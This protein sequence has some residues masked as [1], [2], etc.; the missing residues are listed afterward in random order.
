MPA[1]FDSSTGAAPGET[2]TGA[3]ATVPGAEALADLDRIAVFVLDRERR[4]ERWSPAAAR[5]TGRPVER[6]V[7]AGVGTLFADGVG[8]QAAQLFRAAA[9]TG[10]S[11]GFLP[12]R[13]ADGRIFDVGFRA[14]ALRTPDGRDQV[15]VLAI[16]AGGLRRDGFAHAVFQTLFDQVPIGIAVYDEQRRFMRV[17]RA[18]AE[19]DG[20]SAP[21]H[22]GRRIEEVLSG[23]DD[24]VPLLQQHVL[25]TGEPVRDAFVKAG[26][27]K[28]GTTAAADAGDRRFW[29]MSHARLASADGQV[30]GLTGVIVDVTERQLAFERDEANRRRA[31]VLSAVGDRVAAA[32]DPQRAADEL[33]QA[34]VPAFCD[35]AAIYLLDSADDDRT[36]QAGMRITASRGETVSRH[37]DPSGEFGTALLETL[38]A[39]LA[40]GHARV[41]RESDNRGIVVPLVAHD[42][43]LGAVHFTRA[44]RRERF[45]AADLETV[46]ELAA[47]AAISMDNARLYARERDTA[48]LLQRSLLPERLPT[49]EGTRVAYRYRPGSVGAQV[50]G[51]WFDVIPLPSRRVAFVVGDVMGSG[52]RAAGIMGQFRTAARTL[53]QLDLTPAQVLRE[54]DELARSMS[55][56]H[57]ATCVYAIYNPVEGECVM[58][59]AGHPPPLLVGPGGGVDLVHLE[60]GAPLGVGGQR[61]EEYAFAVD[62]ASALALYT[63]GLVEARDRDI[64][65]GIDELLGAVSKSAPASANAAD[66]GRWL[67]STC[68]AAFEA[69]LGPRSV[70]D[71]TLLLAALDRFPQDQI[72]SWVLTSQP[73]VAARARELV[74]RQLDEWA[75]RDAEKNAD[76]SGL[77]PP[78]N[79]TTDVVELLVS[80][81]VTNALRY[82]RGPIGLRLLR[83]ASSVVCEVSD[84]FDAAPRLRTV[85][86]ADEG[87]RGL[88]LVD[89]LSLDWGSRTTP[90]GKIVWFEV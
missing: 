55:E 71:A 41:V 21:E 29:S 18:F 68:D 60:P 7:G 48:L 46:D 43:L 25:D 58:A 61:F 10:S 74:R 23:I 89:Q 85:H 69:L 4:I 31:A 59:S 77:A 38:D 73:T 90:H 66:D 28:A 52:L 32:L 26:A 78:V 54:L 34:L 16:D 13:H 39:S 79:D 88:Y 17:N 62:P 49:V 14:D 22:V 64:E 80:E 2:T 3:G 47:R 30:L 86:H 33:A 72:A 27:V 84:E 24:S 76:D 12:V 53:A 20:L 65:S 51:D 63:D 57:L 11:A 82:G 70:D 44:A 9:E 15:Q 35:S 67:E 5:L 36:N 83:S 1:A 87:G 42:A 56:S 50:G 81:L 37:D 40:T 6:A 8:A 45:T 19:Y 75:A